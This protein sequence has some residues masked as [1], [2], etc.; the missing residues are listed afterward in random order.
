MRL[1]GEVLRFGAVWSTSVISGVGSNLTTF[2][3]G[4]WIFLE[5]G[6]VTAF[7]VGMLCGSLPMILVGPVSGVVVD[8]FDRRWVLIITD[9]V[10]AA[11][12]AG[13]TYLVFTDQVAV[14]HLY[15]ATVVGAA[16][17][18]F[19]STAY[20]AMTPLLIPKRHLARA[21]G[22]MQVA[23]AANIAAP[24]LAAAMLPLV[25]LGGVLVL[26]LATFA[27]ATVT[28]LVVRLPRR[29]LRADQP[30]TRPSIRE[31]LGY[32]WRHL[33]QRPGLRSLV[34]VLV[35]YNFCFAS[36]AV[37]VQPLILSFGSPS[38]LG[39][40]M[41]VGGSGLF[42]G[43]IVM[44]VWGGP[45]RR[46]RGL[47]LFIAMGGVALVAHAPRPWPVL[48]G[49]A[50]FAMLFTLPVVNSLFNTTL[51]VKV[52]PSGLGRVIATAHTLCRIPSP[53]AFVLVAPLAEYALEPAMRPGGGL[54]GSLG[55]LLGTGPGRG[56][57]TVVL[58]A[59]LLLIVLGTVTL[60]VPAVRRVDTMP[61]ALPEESADP[62][63]PDG[64]PADVE[65]DE[66]T[67]AHAP[68]PG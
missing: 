26:D 30:A 3:F 9:A 33:G 40:L 34:L 50:A 55:Q 27:L 25:G 6:S 20:S 24:L 53:V 64:V 56:I 31:D 28:L 17:G 68:G 57:A 46:V 21:N 65:L 44:G 23:M 62:A 66:R 48:V 37:L 41:F 45:V 7:A 22:L 35:G 2:V 4:V 58:A 32:G 29:I 36:A 13:V 15:L 51:Q 18:T 49:V 19:H 43:S 14:W 59:G 63:E 47:A 52:E 1:R 61:D 42:A 67:A 8:R 39:V 54:A 38:T 60:G 16:G 12:I 10:S 5:T 11:A